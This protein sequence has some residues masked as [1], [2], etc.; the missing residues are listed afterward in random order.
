ME[1]L[2]KDKNVISGQTLDFTQGKKPIKILGEG[3]I[4][5]ILNIKAAAFSRQ[6][7]EK[8]TKVGGRIFK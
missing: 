1:K 3:E 8:I 4:D 2:E 6:A 5:K 7:Q